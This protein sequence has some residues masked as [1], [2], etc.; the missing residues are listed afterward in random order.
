MN[1]TGAKMP[2][3]QFMMSRQ[4]NLKHIVNAQHHS[5][6]M[7]P[8]GMNFT[9]NGAWGMVPHHSHGQSNGGMPPPSFLQQ[10]QSNSKA[11][12]YQ[13]VGGGG[14]GANGALIKSNKG[15]DSGAGHQVTRTMHTEASSIPNT[16][17][18]NT[19]N[20]MKPAFLHDQESML[21]QS[22]LA[23]PPQGFQVLNQK[24]IGIDSD[25]Q[26]GHVATYNYAQQMIPK[27]GVSAST[28][29]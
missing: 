18:I 11:G 14:Q 21:K 24:L 6:Q 13:R 19:K 26:M 9:N 7:A 28:S 22:L 16:I 17:H 4:S 29:N 2:A 20:L 1:P 8:N 15:Q 12:S 25:P 10:P 3:P 23:S 5:M 27:S